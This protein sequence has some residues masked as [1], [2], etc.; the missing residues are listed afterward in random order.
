MRV[1]GLDLAL[2]RTGAAVVSVGQGP[3]TCAAWHFDGGPEKG[4]ERL[5]KIQANVEESVMDADLVVIEGLAYRA[6]D[7]HRALAGV[8]WIVTHRLWEWGKAVAVVPP[9]SLKQYATGVGNA[10][11]SAVTAAV[12]SDAFPYFRTQDDNAADAAVL[13]SMGARAK[14]RPVDRVPMEQQAALL[15]AEWP[16]AWRNGE[17]A[18]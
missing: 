16:W 15:K 9:A 2:N 1:V 5:A 18:E 13:A 4:H 6:Y 14:G 3:T 12:N 8:W 17:G 10:K 11:K 7:A